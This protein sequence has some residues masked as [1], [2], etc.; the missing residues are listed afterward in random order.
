MFWPVLSFQENLWSR[1]QLKCFFCEG[2]LISGSKILKNILQN[3][4]LSSRPGFSHF[5]TPNSQLFINK[6]LSESTSKLDLVLHNY[7]ESKT[8]FCLGS[9]TVP[10]M[11]CDQLYQLHASTPKKLKLKLKISQ[12]SI[13]RH[14]PELNLH[15]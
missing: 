11:K 12:N 7:I 1:F 5:K 9:S 4:W 8:E 14:F 2:T 15:T 3:L 13:L 10:P 6:F